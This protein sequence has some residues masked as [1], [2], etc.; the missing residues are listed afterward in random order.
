MLKIGH[1]L[2]RKSLRQNASWVLYLQ[3]DRIFDFK[4]A[5]LEDRIPLSVRIFAYD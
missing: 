2:L 5:F 1:E 3:P 4:V